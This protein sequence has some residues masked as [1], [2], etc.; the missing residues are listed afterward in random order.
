MVAGKKEVDTPAINEFEQPRDSEDQD[1]K[2][3]RV[4]SSL[5]KLSEEAQEAR[6]EGGSSMLNLLHKA[7]KDG[8]LEAFEFL[9]NEMPPNSN[10]DLSAAKFSEDGL[11]PLHVASKNGHQEMVKFLLNKGVSTMVTDEAKNTPLHLAATHGHLEV[12]LDLLAHESQ[13]NEEACESVRSNLLQ[14]TNTNGLSPFGC[15]IKAAP[16]PHFH[17]AKEFLNVIHGN[18]ANVIPDFGKLQLFPKQSNAVLPLEKPAKIFIVGDADA[19]KSTLVKSLQ[20]GRSAFPRRLIGL[21]SSRLVMN[22]DEHFSGIIITDFANANF[23]RVLFHDLAGHTNYFNESLLEPN[24]RLEHSIFIVVVD[25]RFNPQRTEEQLIYWLNFLHYHTSRLASEGTKPNIVVVGSH[26]DMKRGGWRSGEKF[27]E[28]Y[29]EALKKRPQL[30]D[31]FNQLMKPV[32]LD[33]RRF[34]GLEARQLRS[35]LQK[36]CQTFIYSQIEATS[37][38]S[39]CYILSQVLFDNK[40]LP[41]F[42]KLLDLAHMIGDLAAKPVPNASLYKLLPTEPTKLMEICKTLHK[43]NRLVIVQNPVPSSDLYHWIVHDIHALLTEIDRRLASLKSLSRSSSEEF[44]ATYNVAELVVDHS[45]SHFGII[46]REKLEK[47]FSGCRRPSRTGSGSSALKISESVTTHT[48]ATSSSGSFSL[49]SNLAV[50]L[51]LKYK[52]CEPISSNDPAFSS[53]SFFFPCLLQEEIGEPDLWERGTNYSFAWCVE[54]CPQ[55]DNVVEYFLPRFL[56]KLLLCFIEKFLIHHPDNQEQDDVSTMSSSNDTTVVWSRGVSWSTS[57]DIKVHIELNDSAIILSMYSQEGKELSCLQLRNKILATIKDERKKW[58]PDVATN[59][60]IIPFGEK[61][62][63][64]LK[65]F[66]KKQGIPLDSVKKAILKGKSKVEG[67][68]IQALLFYE[69]C[70]A[71]SRLRD[72]ICNPNHTSEI[73]QENLSEIIDEL[74]RD[75]LQHFNISDHHSDSTPQPHNSSTQSI[76]KN[77]EEEEV[78]GLQDSESQVFTSASPLPIP[79]AMAREISEWNITPKKLIE[80]MNSVSI[81]DIDEFLQQLEVSI[82][83][84][85]ILKVI[86]HNYPCFLTETCP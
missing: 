39:I 63:V 22:I 41:P 26:K 66:D 2:Q 14:M 60:F 58:Q 71:V 69:P 61:F 12:A 47:I 72:V 49:N 23:G 82:A 55:D 74:G 40:E 36:Y 78:Q 42:L 8:K 38:T 59:E 86:D 33:C 15:A 16:E 43:H 19:G 37:P 6:E 56:K 24:D 34:E 52:Y 48:L 18:P 21:I 77:G 13:H 4:R 62:P 76:A 85:I 81:M 57:D 80:C 44:E 29:T 53:E 30:N 75:F 73:N 64:Q 27:N 20:E 35:C 67:A 65:D 5:I 1:P 3:R 31:Y 32:S 9:L 70:M 11:T 68:D 79:N 7:C 83:I 84:I 45:V 10:I 54:P 17:I 25:L 46:T 51:L 28:V 50:D